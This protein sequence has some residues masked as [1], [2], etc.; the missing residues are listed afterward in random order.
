MKRQEELKTIV[1]T[2]NVNLTLNGVKLQT[3]RSELKLRTTYDNL[4]GMT[5]SQGDPNRPPI[6]QVIDQRAT[7]F[8]SNL[9][10]SQFDNRDFLGVKN[11]D[12]KKMTK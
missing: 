11:Q 3:L 2:N 8:R 10:V 6:E 12:V 4:A 5:E 7:I 9:Y 1:G